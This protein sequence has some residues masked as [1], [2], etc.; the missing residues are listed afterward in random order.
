MADSNS[1]LPVRSENPLDLQFQLVDPVTPSQRAVVDANGSLSTLLKDASGNAVTTQANGGQRALDVGINVAG[2]QIDPRDIRALTATDVVTAAQGAASTAADGWWVRPTDGTNSQVYLATG[3]AKVSVTQPLPAGTNSIGTV[4][5]QLQDNAGTAI[6]LGQKVMASS[7]PVTI[8][9]DQTDLGVK[10]HDG[11]DN[12]ITSQASGG[13][14]A[15]DVGINVAGAQVDP[16]DIR[17]LTDF[18]HV[19]ADLAVAGAPVTTLNPVPVTV[20][21]E[22]LGTEVNKYNTTSSLAAGSPVNHDYTITSLK[23]FKGRKFWASGSGKI[24]AEVQISADG[25][26]FTTFW[27]GF[28]STANPNIS[29]DLDVLTITE[30]GTG[31]KIRIIMTNKD[32]QAQDVYSTISGSEY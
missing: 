19:T 20:V 7:I 4:K 9:S 3:E 10:L 26:T 17:A 18:D 28:N 25:T 24:K 30:T 5:A 8:A 31:S 12:A 6:T 23:T 14:R 15:L 2:V 16:R 21:S 22:V 29:I 13:Q 11:A 1:S 27:V 32:N